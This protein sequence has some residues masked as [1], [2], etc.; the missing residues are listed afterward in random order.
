MDVKRKLVFDAEQFARM[1]KKVDDGG[2]IRGNIVKF[3]MNEC[4]FRK[5][6]KLASVS[7]FNSTNLLHFVC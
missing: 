7:E 5:H 6:L 2:S 3:G 1:K 4:T